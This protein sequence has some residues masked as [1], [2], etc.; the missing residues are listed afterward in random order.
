VSDLTHALFG[1][2]RARTLETLPYAAK[3]QGWQGTHG[4]ETEAQDRRS[5][6][7]LETPTC[8]RHQLPIIAGY[9]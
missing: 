5:S 4:L 3:A 1:R 2:G 7:G 9:A 8:L 6:H